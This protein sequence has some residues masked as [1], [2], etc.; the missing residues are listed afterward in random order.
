MLL[1]TERASSLSN[2]G[3]DQESP[4]SHIHLSNTT[5]QLTCSSNPGGKHDDEVLYGS[6][7]SSD[8]I[9]SGNNTGS[10]QGSHLGS[11]RT[12]GDDSNPLSSNPP[13]SASGSSSYGNYP[14]TTGRSAGTDE[15]TG[16]SGLGSSNAFASG[17]QESRIPGAFDDDASSTTAI[18]SGIPGHG[19]S[20]LSG[21]SDINKPLPREPGSSSLGSGSHANVGPHSSGLENKL[22]PRVDSDLD[23]SR[24]LGRNTGT[25]GS[26]LTGSNL[27]D[28]SVGK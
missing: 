16:S 20:G 13:T 9:H 28:R 21:T 26:G 2:Y 15:L 5:L 27:P 4:V 19:A 7:Q 23:G 11:S 6:G 1:C 18:R 22:D 12:G 3:E 14:S 8:P 10:G 17:A 25:T 24:G